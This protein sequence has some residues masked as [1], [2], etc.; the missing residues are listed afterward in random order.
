MNKSAIGTQGEWQEL[1]PILIDAH[2]LHQDL[3]YVL[4]GGFYY[5]THLR[6]VQNQI[7]VFDLELLAKLFDH[8][9]I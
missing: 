8:F 9:S 1:M 4:I 5:A 6:M 3:L 2:H 7:S